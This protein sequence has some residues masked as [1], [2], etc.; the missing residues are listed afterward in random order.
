MYC[1]PH[2]RFPSGAAA[3]GLSA[4]FGGIFQGRQGQ[5]FQDDFMYDRKI[6][7]EQ[8]RAF[9]VLP[10]AKLRASKPRPGGAGNKNRSM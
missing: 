1:F 10:D 9:S 2:F 8:G 3:R 5:G 6:S 4:H 7:Q